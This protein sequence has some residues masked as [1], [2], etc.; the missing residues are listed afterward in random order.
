MDS[1]ST[2][3]DYLY[4]T[5]NSAHELQQSNFLLEF[6]DKRFANSSFKIEKVTKASK[7]S[8]LY[9]IRI[10]YK[11]KNYGGKLIRYNFSIKGNFKECEN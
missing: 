10:N 3:L 8:R 6:D 7:N 11:C 9:S 4:I 2:D 1:N 5:I